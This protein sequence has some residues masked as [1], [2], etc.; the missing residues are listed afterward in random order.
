VLQVDQLSGEVLLVGREVEVAVAAEVEEDGLLFS[1]FLRF[2]RQVYGRFDG[3][4]Y[5]GAGTMPS[6]LANVT[7]ASKVG[8]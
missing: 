8:F 2:E 5:L 3:V 4:R 6:V 7:P 1:F